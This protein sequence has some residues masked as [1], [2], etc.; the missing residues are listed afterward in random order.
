[1]KFYISSE[2]IK[3]K[4]F[5]IY[6]KFVIAGATSALLAISLNIILV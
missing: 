1:M 3:N 2:K 5:K 6:I 4:N